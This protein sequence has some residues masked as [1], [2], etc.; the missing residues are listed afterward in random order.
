METLLDEI[1]E[2]I[3]KHSHPVKIGFMFYE[4]LVKSGYDN[5][6]IQFASAELRALA[7]EGEVM[8]DAVK[9]H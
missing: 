5:E 9:Q 7:V 8:V 4:L 1:N 6:E 2:A 3:S